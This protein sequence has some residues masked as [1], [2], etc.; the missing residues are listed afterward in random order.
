MVEVDRQNIQVG[1]YL[2]FKHH[3]GFWKVTSEY[4]QQGTWKGVTESKKAFTYEIVGAESRGYKP[5]KNPQRYYDYEFRM[6]KD[7]E[8]GK[9]KIF[10]LKEV[11]GVVEV[12]KW[13]KIDKSIKSKKVNN[14]KPQTKQEEKTETQITEQTANNFDSIINHEITITADTDTRDNSLL[15]VVKI[16]D[17]LSNEE[18][19]NV[20]E[21][22]KA[23]KG[24]YSKFKKG[25]I[26]KYDPTSI[27]KP[28]QQTEQTAE[29]ATEEETKT[30]EQQTAENIIDIST[31]IISNLSLN[32]ISYL[33]NAEY[34][35][36]LT[37]YLQVKNIEITE[38]IL[39]HIPYEGLKLILQIIQ[40]EKNNK[41]PYEP[42]EIKDGFIYDCHFKEWDMSITEIQKYCNEFN[43]PWYDMGCK[44]GFKGLI[45]E[46]ARQVKKISDINGSIFFIDNEMSED[47]YNRIGLKM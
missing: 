34:R 22:F 16:I 40:A 42:E 27:L 15:W 18:Y 20:A 4:M 6:L 45:A 23:L 46:Q 9:T 28:E 13:E 33:D 38:L 10:E 29:E 14:S 7:L 37:K 35:K 12:E 31:E 39:N 32:Y 47:E 3:G 41:N 1:D 36:E 8:A 19:K 2:T 17:R 43:L 44:I 24:Y 21:Q 11:E 5:L 26:F 25:F 30:S